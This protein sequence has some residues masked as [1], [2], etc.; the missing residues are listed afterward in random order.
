M[1]SE[2]LKKP[3]PAKLRRQEEEQKKLEQQVP[4]MFVEV[5]PATA[6]TEPPKKAEYYSDKSSRAANPEPK[7]DSTVPKID[8]KQTQVTKT[9]DVAKT[10]PFPLQPAPAPTPAEPPA[11]K[12]IE[13]ARV[14]P[15]PKPPQPKPVEVKEPEPKAIEP[16][17]VEPKPA[18]PKRPEPKPIVVKPVEPKPVVVKPVEPKPI[19][20]PRQE[21]TETKPDERP[22]DLFKPK[23]ALTPG[24]LAMVRP[25]PAKAPRQEP[26]PTP[27]PRPKTIK[28][29]LARQASGGIAGNRMKQEGGVKRHGLES[30][31]DVIATPFGAYDAALV[32]AVQARWDFLLDQRDYARDRTGRVVLRFRLHPDGSVSEM[33]IMENTV[34]LTLALLCQSAINDPSPYAQWPSDMRRLVGADYREVT[35]TFYYN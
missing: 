13:Q 18:E 30:S 6:V 5:N 17:P 1:L 21:L 12:P 35:F 11:P 27:R 23:P 29:A 2:L 22:G 7:A 26:G 31:L 20:P 3:D 32:A 8:G 10:Q 25:E 33:R 16:K 34:D 19:E 28:E 24:E 9:E 14:E 15:E 4:L